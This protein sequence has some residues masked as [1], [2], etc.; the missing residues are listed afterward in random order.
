MSASSAENQ[1]GK[2][3]IW[4]DAVGVEQ[5]KVKTIDFERLESRTVLL[6]V[7]AEVSNIGTTGGDEGELFHLRAETDE[8]EKEGR[9]GILEVQREIS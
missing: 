3:V 9:L 2:M 6:E 4:Q 8:V 1:G 7:G 5:S